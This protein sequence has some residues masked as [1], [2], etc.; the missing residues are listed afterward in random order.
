MVFSPFGTVTDMGMGFGKNHADARLS[1]LLHLHGIADRNPTRH[2]V[3]KSGRCSR[4]PVRSRLYADRACFRLSD[5]AVL[6]FGLVR[7][8]VLR[9]HHLC[10]ASGGTAYGIGHTAS[11]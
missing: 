4:I 3:G 6:F 7:F 2:L 1:A 8:P 11:T 10:H 9:H 5:S